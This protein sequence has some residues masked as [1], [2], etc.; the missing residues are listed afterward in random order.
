MVM[1]LAPDSLA[2]SMSSL[3]AEQRS[4]LLDDFSDHEVATLLYDWRFWARPTQL[5]PLGEWRIWL[6]LAGRGWGKTRVGAEWVRMSVQSHQLVNLIAPTSDDARDVMVEGE[7]GVLAICPPDE[8]P[9]YLPSKRRLDWPNGARSLIFTADEPERLRGKQHMRI[10]A[11]EVAAWRYPEAW[12]QTLMGLRL[13]SDPRAVVTTTPKPVRLVRDLMADPT[14]T[15]TRGSTYENLGNLA[16]QFIARIVSRYEG[17]RLGRQELHAELLEDVPGALWTRARLDINRVTTYPDLARAVV[18]VDPSGGSSNGHDEQGIVVAGK[19]VDGHAYVLAD[20]SCRLSPDGW[21]RRAIQ[22]YLDFAADRIVY[23]ANYGGE[24]VKTTI[25]TTAQ[26]MGVTVALREVHAS[27]GKAIRAE[28]IA[29]LD[30]QGRLHIVGSLPDLEDQLCTWSPESGQSP[31]R[32]DA[33]VWA[34][35]DLMLESAEVRFY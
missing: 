10:W 17:T 4:R 7:S 30:E 18:A 34:A 3:S 2:G 13:G 12:D 22:A 29:A 16:P 15:L 6:V 35:T 5:P 21:A 8:R 32:L 20:R 23:E 26:A 1:T 28:P 11:D 24:M 9:E 27:R 19:G 14:A 33:L 31:D 25:T